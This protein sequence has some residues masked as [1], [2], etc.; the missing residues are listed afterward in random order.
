MIDVAA[1]FS[2]KK[3]HFLCFDFHSS[4]QHTQWLGTCHTCLM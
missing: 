3:L 2:V 4:K 1:L